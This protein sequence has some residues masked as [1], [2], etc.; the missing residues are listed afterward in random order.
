[1]VL[2][3]AART[4]VDRVGLI[5]RDVERASR[6]ALAGDRVTKA[7]LNDD[8]SRACLVPSIDRRIRPTPY[9]HSPTENTV[10][11]HSKSATN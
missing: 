6:D 8:V 2:A 3:F 7:H 11:S 5:S 9:L 1:M 4:N 10:R